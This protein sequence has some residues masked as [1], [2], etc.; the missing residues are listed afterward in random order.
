MNA[1]NVEANGTINAEQRKD[2]AKKQRAIADNFRSIANKIQIDGKQ[3]EVKASR[4]LQ[5]NTRK[6]KVDDLTNEDIED[7]GG[8]GV[9]S[10][11]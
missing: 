5:A 7:D 6:Y 2:I 1:Y 10:L 4:E 3:S 11:F 8:E 9:S